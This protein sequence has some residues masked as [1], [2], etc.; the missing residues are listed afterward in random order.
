MHH[1]VALALPQVTA[2]DLANPCVGRRTTLVRSTQ[3]H[4][5]AERIILR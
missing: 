1:V 4:R 5:R 2:F 3:H